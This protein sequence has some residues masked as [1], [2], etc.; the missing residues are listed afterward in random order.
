MYKVSGMTCGHCVGTVTKAVQTVAPAAEV[1]VD[2]KKGIVDVVGQHD[3]SRV[4]AAIK[5]AGYTAQPG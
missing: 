4:V 2:L 1:K 5:A 3:A